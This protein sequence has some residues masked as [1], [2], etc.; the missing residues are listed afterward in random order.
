ME[1]TWIVT[2]DEARARIF[3]QSGAGQPLQE[4]EDM[5]DAEGRMQAADINTDRLDPTAAGKSVHG[6]GGALPGKLYQPA[7]TPEAHEAEKF[8]RDLARVLLK[9]R[10]EGRYDKLVLAAAPKFL[11]VLRQQLDPQLAALLTRQIDK[12]YTHSSAHQ[13]REQLETLEQKP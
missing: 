3:S 6:T 4:I 11:G 12:D 10:Q 8:A 7:Q 2:A 5:V 9:A 1:T 13:L